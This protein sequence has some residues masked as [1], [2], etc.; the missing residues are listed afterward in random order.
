M[1]PTF[2]DYLQAPDVDQDSY[3]SEKPHFP[4]WVIAIAQSINTL[5]DPKVDLPLYNDAGMLKAI[6]HIAD[7][8][9]MDHNEPELIAAEYLKQRRL[10]RRD[11][12]QELLGM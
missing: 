10:D 3:Y 8:D 4:S 1:Q 11:R 9:H 7:M 5:H 6:Q 2:R 12:N